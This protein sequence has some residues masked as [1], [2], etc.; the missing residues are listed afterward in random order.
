MT[1]ISAQNPFSGLKIFGYDFIMADPPWHFLNWSE[2]GEGKNATAHYECSSLDLIKA[3]PVGH[4][5]K[6]DAVL[7]LWATNPM[8]PQAFEVMAAWGF[9]FKTAGHWVKRTKNNLLAFGTGYILRCAG[10][11]FLIGTLGKPKTAKNVRSVFE[12]QVREHSRKPEEAFEWAEKLLPN[13][14]GRVELYSRGW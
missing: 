6:P 14:A 12:G 1:H 7:M 13:A 10:E 9:E 4:L 3:Q 5:A 2:A 11:P 8:L